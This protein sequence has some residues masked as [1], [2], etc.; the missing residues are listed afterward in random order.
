MS[1]PKPTHV[2]IPHE[3]WTQMLR[4]LQALQTAAQHSRQELP[5]R[6]A[7]LTTTV[8]QAANAAT[9]QST[10]APRRARS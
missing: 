3:L 1:T 10:A 5:A 9:Y 2:T 8:L 7:T 4:D 6:A